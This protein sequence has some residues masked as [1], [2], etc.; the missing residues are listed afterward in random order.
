LNP[1]FSGFDPFLIIHYY[2]EIVLPNSKA[3]V[4]RIRAGRFHSKR[5][6]KAIDLKMWAVIM[7]RVEEIYSVK[8][9]DHLETLTNTFVKI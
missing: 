5:T 3:P 1:H 7:R 8:V 4:N 9:A 2:T 6:F